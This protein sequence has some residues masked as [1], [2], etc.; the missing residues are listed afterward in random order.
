MNKHLTYSPKSSCGFGV[1][2]YTSPKSP[3]RTCQAFYSKTNLDKLEGD[4]KKYSGLAKENYSWWKQLLTSARL[5]H[6]APP[7]L[8]PNC[9]LDKPRPSVLRSAVV[10]RRCEEEKAMLELDK[11]LKKEGKQKE[12][13]TEFQ[14]KY[15][16]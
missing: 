4:I 8:L 13:K 10:D 12:V 3:L 1:C 14:S 6:E 5:S 15:L 9:T 7:K 16:F 11:N 2:G